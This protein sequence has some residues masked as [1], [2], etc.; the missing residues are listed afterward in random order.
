MAKKNIII[1]SYLTVVVMTVVGNLPYTAASHQTMAAPRQ[2]L[3]A[4]QQ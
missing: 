3:Q 1:Y 2:L 4:L